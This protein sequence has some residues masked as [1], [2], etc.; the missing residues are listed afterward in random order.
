MKTSVTMLSP[1]RELFGIKIRQQSKTGHLNL[2]DLQGAYG[3]ARL[4]H[5]WSDRNVYDVL[6]TKDNAERIYYLLSERGLLD[7]GIPD[8]TELLDNQ[9]MVKTL[10]SLGVYKTAGRGANKT[11]WCDPY[12]WVL[13]AMELNPM[14]YAKTVIWL[15]DALLLNRIEAGNF[16]RGFAGAISKWSP[17]VDFARIARG[18]NFVVFGGHQTGI[19]DTATSDQL[20]QLAALE[21]KLTFAI[22]M[23][24]IASEQQL[25][26]VLVKMWRDRPGNP[27]QLA[28]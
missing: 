27:F 19:R 23:G 18:L 11:T 15:T 21:E 6:D 10:K 20:R 8:F 14:I 3:L 13:V 5:G 1:D 12:V 9:G 7:S 4:Q 22:Q 24:F 17:S 28:A 26:D 2:S 16:Y 25:L